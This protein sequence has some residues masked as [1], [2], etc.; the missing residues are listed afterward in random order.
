MK[1]LFAFLFVGTAAIAC[2]PPVIQKSG[3]N[4]MKRLEVLHAIDFHQ[5]T[6]G[7]TV[8]G[9]GC[10]LAEHF[11]IQ[12]GFAN[13][14]CQVSIYRTRPDR[15]R[16]MPMPVTL[17]LLWNAKEKCGNA[18]IEIQNPLKPVAASR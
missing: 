3:E 11:D 1:Y 10:T 9:S 8:I 6:I 18:E 14:K 7:I 4:D 12:T 5:D 17:E 13:G 2:T 15:C 16:R